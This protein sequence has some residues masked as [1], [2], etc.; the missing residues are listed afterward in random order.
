LDFEEL[1]P[2]C[3]GNTDE[4]VAWSLPTGTPFAQQADGGCFSIHSSQ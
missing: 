1:K 3:L 2:K 4:T